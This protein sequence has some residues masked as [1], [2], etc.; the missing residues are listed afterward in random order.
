MAQRLLAAILLAMAGSFMVAGARAETAVDTATDTVVAAHYPP[1]MIEGGGER[2]GFAVEVLR[3]AARRAG[4]EVEITFLPYQRA[5][6]RVQNDPATLMPALFRGKKREDGYH[7]VVA[8][9]SAKL[10]FATLSG[11]VHD[12]D[13]ARSLSTIVVEGGTTGDVLLTRLGFD[14]LVRVNSPDSSARMLEV[15]RADAW[16]LTRRLMRQVW[17]RL[18]MAPTLVFGNIVHEVPIFMVASPS[19][20]EDV[21]AVYRAAVTSMKSD[22][23]LDAILARYEPD[24]GL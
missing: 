12:L 17:E 18:E 24:S 23:T 3:E 7:W 19:L 14:N 5:L 11:P 15:G 13:T 4:R 22:G 10:R 16:L 21:S 2:P 6:Y 8:I 20:P 9:Q 1:L